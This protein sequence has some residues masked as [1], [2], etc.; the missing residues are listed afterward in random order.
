[1]SSSHV[2]FKEVPTD[3]W[4]DKL[5]WKAG[6]EDAALLTAR[7][8]RDKKVVVKLTVGEKSIEYIVLSL[9]KDNTSSYSPNLPAIYGTMSCYEKNQNIADN[10][11]RLKDRGLCYG[12][13]K[14]MDSQKIYMSVIGFIDARTLD[15][16]SH[17][18]LP[19]EQVISLVM[20]GLFTIYQLYY[21]FGI[22]HR[23]FNGGN[24]LIGPTNRKELEYKIVCAPYRYFDHE[25]DDARC[26][27]HACHMKVDTHGARLYLIDFDQATIYHQ[28]YINSSADYYIIQEAHKFMTSILL[29]GRS[30][31]YAKYMEVKE[32]HYDRILE[33]CKR[34]HERYR[35]EQT[36]YSN[37]YMIDRTTIGLRV[38][39]D[40]IRKK[41]D[42]PHTY[43]I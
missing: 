21:V 31:L 26:F 27:D 3:A 5:L 12:N 15:S 38:Y 20:Q 19:D 10:F 2:Y 17:V 25:L 33:C 24:I 6:T 9:I 32:A 8:M 35:K 14:D 18:K 42:L 39:I 30:E 41:F 16:L 23:D 1:M 28:K 7:Y 4:L 29:L 34:H 13:K 43:R 11:K 22:M 37:C 40:H 36:P